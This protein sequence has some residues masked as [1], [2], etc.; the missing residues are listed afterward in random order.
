MEIDAH[1]ARIEERLGKR[2][3]VRAVRTPEPELRGYVEVRPHRVLIEYSE[4]QPGYFWAYE[5]LERLLEWVEAGGGSSYF[6]DHAGRLL[7]VPADLDATGSE[8]GR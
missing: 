6:Y 7:R 4:E 1:I 8:P 2:L 3:I 5:L